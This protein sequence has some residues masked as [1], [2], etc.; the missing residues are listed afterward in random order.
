MK[1]KKTSAILIA[2]LLPLA[3][4]G[5]SETYSVDYAK[6]NSRRSDEFSPVYYKNGLVFCSNRNRNLFKNYL[7]PE[8]K[9]LLKIN[10]VDTVSGKVKLFSKDLKT[11]F[12][13]GPA[14]FSSNGDTIYFSRNLK[15]DGTIEEN[16]PRNKLG[17]FTAVLENK[18]WV[19]I[20]DIRFN[21][22]YF[23]I[24]TPFISP[25]GRRLFFASDNPAGYGGTDIYY[26]DWKVDY[27]DDPV[28]LGPVINTKGNESFPFVNSEGGLFF[29]SDGH[30]GQGGKDI[31]YTKQSKNKW[32]TPVNLDSPVNSKYDDFGLIAD[33]EMNNGFF[34]SKRGNSSDIYSFKTNI[35]QI[36]YCEQQKVNQYCFRFA[37]EGKIPFDGRYL[38]LVWSFGDGATSTGLNTEHCFK[39]PGM[40]SVKLEAIDKKTGQVFF[41]KLSYEL[42]LKNI[43]QPVINAQVSGLTGTPLDF[44]G[45]S[46]NFPGSDILNYTWYFGDGNRSEGEKLSHSY[47]SKGDYEVKLGLIVR[48]K[49]TGVI[50]EACSILPVRIFSDKLE[51]NS[52][53]K[54]EVK[55]APLI[56]VLEYEYALPAKMY[57]S[58]N[59]INQ[60]V[61]YRIEIINSKRKLAPD[62]KLLKN[63]PKKYSIK[64]EFFPEQN[65]YS[66]TIAEELGIMATYPSF[67]EITS[68]G[69]TN[70]RVIA[71]NLED[72]AARELNN[73][74]RVFGTSTDTF[75]RK[76]DSGLTSA[77]TQL[78]DLVLGF[79]SKYPALKLELAC[80]SDNTGQA[81]SNMSLSQKRADAMLNYLL[82]NG[83]NR[84]RLSA[85]GYGSA[86][87]IASN[88]QESDKKL[89][90]RINFTIVGNNH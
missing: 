76:N 10:F 60:D 88:T 40:Y 53:D 77:G 16:S 27:W 34:S 5:Q 78:M 81:A 36:F 69:Y 32:L 17:I 45:L 57:S 80:H 19:K 30:P 52:Y 44:N 7:T 37:D 11:K 21:N 59:Y 38:Q 55:P 14:S 24:T 47:L 22:E 39:G 31:F 74:K 48:N 65:S 56:N 4:I 9:G 82:I 41:T 54:R 43:E 68:L 87:P 33:P 49:K 67:S 15:V 79:L 6:F 62:D 50:K 35:H 29:A 70:A 46:S 85:K 73:L 42:D 3:V 75:F 72:P 66:Y 84:A 28:N 13:D 63:V 89:N 71:Y 90:R 64:E 86:I 1:I 18:S 61:V 58:E 51:K 26:C 83:I 12:N 8:N 25:D 20:L 2:F 23:N